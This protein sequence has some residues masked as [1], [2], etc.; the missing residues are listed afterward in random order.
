V[1]Q[2]AFDRLGYLMGAPAK[3]SRCGFE[4]K[5]FTQMS[6][7]DPHDDPPAKRRPTPIS[8]AARHPGV[9]CGGTAAGDCRSLAPPGFATTAQWSTPRTGPWRPPASATHTG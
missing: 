2:P 9:T 8:G 7:R 5:V 3:L 6:A 4:P 1:W